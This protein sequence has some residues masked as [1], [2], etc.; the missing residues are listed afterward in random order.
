MTDLMDDL[1]R[2]AKNLVVTLDCE[3]RNEDG[4]NNIQAAVGEL[5]QAIHALE[6]RRQ[7]EYERMFGKHEDE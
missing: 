1:L 5:S 3:P 4:E 7:S 2:T 6:S